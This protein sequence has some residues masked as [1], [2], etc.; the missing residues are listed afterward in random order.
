MRTVRHVSRQ[1]QPPRHIW[2]TVIPSVD[3]ILSGGFPKGKE[4]G[5]GAGGERNMLLT[6][7]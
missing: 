6:D 7:R 2:R 1:R 4:G 5:K 3:E